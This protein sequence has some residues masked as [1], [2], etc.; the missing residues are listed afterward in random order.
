MNYLSVV[1]KHQALLDIG[2]QAMLR[3]N[4]AIHAMPNANKAM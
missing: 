3:P 4:I 1:P 2:S